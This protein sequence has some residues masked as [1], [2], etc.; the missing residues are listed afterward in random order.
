MKI[1]SYSKN[2]IILLI[3]I[4]NEIFSKE[5]ELITLNR[6]S[7]ITLVIN[8]ND[9]SYILR[10]DSNI[11]LPDEMIVNGYPQSKEYFA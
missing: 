1:F 10:E 6:I 5:N 4:I 3:I 2:N 8:G 11:R 7:E 9:N